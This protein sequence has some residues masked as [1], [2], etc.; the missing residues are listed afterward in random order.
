VAIDTKSA[1]ALTAAA[2]A[3]CE[4]LS[5]LY[6]SDA[7]RSQGQLRSD[8]ALLAVWV[9][10]LIEGPSTVADAAFHASLRWVENPAYIPVK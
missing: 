8:V 1:D 3:A 7:T 4:D 6:T 5:S 2:A 9:E 10:R